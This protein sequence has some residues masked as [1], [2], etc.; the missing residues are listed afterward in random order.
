MESAERFQS[1]E[2]VGGS[3]PSAIPGN[4]GKAVCILNCHIGNRNNAN[5]TPEISISN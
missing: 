1:S 3:L 2:F 4:H 5:T